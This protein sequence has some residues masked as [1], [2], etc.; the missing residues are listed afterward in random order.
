MNKLNILETPATLVDLV[1]SVDEP[2]KL[3]VVGEILVPFKGLLL[4]LEQ[5]GRY[6]ELSVKVPDDELIKL[7]EWITLFNE[8][9]LKEFGEVKE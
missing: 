4:K 5:S 2:S 3:S 7:K 6:S 8:T 9:C 1:M